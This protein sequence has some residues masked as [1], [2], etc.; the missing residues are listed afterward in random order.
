VAP[1]DLQ[2]HLKLGKFPDLPRHFG[3]CGAGMTS[4]L[5]SATG[6]IFPTSRGPMVLG[7]CNQLPLTLPPSFQL[8][9][10][11]AHTCYYGNSDASEGSLS[12]PKEK[13]SDIHI[14]N[15]S[16]DRL[17]KNVSKSQQ[18]QQPSP[19]SHVFPKK[20]SLEETDNDVSENTAAVDAVRDCRSD[21]NSISDT[22]STTACTPA[23]FTLFRPFEDTSDRNT[24]AKE[25]DVTRKVSSEAG[26]PLDLRMFGSNSYI[27]YFMHN[28]GDISVSGFTNDVYFENEHYQIVTPACKEQMN[29]R[30]IDGLDIAQHWPVSLLATSDADALVDKMERMRRMW[31][32]GSDLEPWYPSPGLLQR[33]G[34]KAGGREKYTCKFC[35][36]VFPRSANLT[37]HLRTHTG[38][39]PYKCRQ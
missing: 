8:C 22:T 36:K 21:E 24:K 17:I 23:K 29:I 14:N 6:D 39:Q 15:M 35:G 32:M 38:E 2:R 3:G 1:T 12:P 4:S 16:N 31:E 26:Q 18:L 34:E 30:N 9:S 11:I 10:P 25:V 20:G 5:A 33:L 28:I 7:N 37:R 19:G 27:N 13:E